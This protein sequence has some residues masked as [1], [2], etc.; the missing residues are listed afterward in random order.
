MPPELYRANTGTNSLRARS[1][2][3]NRLSCSIPATCPRR[4]LKCARWLR[5]LPAW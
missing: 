5:H 4:R 3:I 2:C 1:G